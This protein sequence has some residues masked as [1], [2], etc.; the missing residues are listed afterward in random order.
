[1]C[2]TPA[3]GEVCVLYSKSA[4]RKV[5]RGNHIINVFREERVGDMKRK[6]HYTSW[7]ATLATA[8]ELARRCYDATITFGNTPKVDLLA[9]TKDGPAF[10]VQVKGISR[11]GG[12]W[13]QKGFFDESTEQDL[14]LF[15]VVVPLDT[16]KPFQFF[17]MTHEESKKAYASQRKVK[18]DG[19]PYKEGHEGL[20]WGVYKMHKDRWDKLPGAVLGGKP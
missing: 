15:I 13:I 9:A 20:S 6:R 17:I 1:M 2:P 4:R 8:A 7:A 14:F 12:L 10:K 16:A 11:E 18:R 3:V 19:S 5:L